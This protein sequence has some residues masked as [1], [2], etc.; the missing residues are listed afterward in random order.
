MEAK[1]E[2]NMELLLNGFP[3][4]LFINI[5]TIGEFSDYMEYVKNL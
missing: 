2:T 5:T 1:M 4:K 3:S